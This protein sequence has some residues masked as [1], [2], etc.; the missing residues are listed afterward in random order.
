MVPL[1]KALA[2]FYKLLIVTMFSSAAVW[3]QFSVK[4]FKLQV[5]IGYLGNGER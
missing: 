1:D 3:P 5:T 2:T 4:S